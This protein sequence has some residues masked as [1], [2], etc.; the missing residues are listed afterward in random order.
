MEKSK[1]LDLTVTKSLAGQPLLLDNDCIPVFE[2]LGMNFAE[3]SGEAP[4]QTFFH[5]E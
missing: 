5:V 1:F 4:T 3:P 2:K